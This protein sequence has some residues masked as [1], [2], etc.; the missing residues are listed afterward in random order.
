MIDIQS[1][2]V[3]GVCGGGGGGVMK[4]ENSGS[5]WPQLAPSLFLGKNQLIST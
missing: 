5:D 3:T 2:Q 1:D 4:T